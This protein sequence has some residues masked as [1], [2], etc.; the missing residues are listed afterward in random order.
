MDS[1]TIHDINSSDLN[2]KKEELNLSEP[3]NDKISNINGDEVGG[4]SGGDRG[5]EGV[6]EG[7]AISEGYEDEEVKNQSDSE[8]E[9]IFENC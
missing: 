4:I 7:V 2:E 1:S 8:N 9:V 5:D 3:T 6:Q